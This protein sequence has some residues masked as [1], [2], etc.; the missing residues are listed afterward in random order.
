[1]IKIDTKKIRDGEGGCNYKTINLLCTAYD[2][3]QKEIERLNFFK[4]GHDGIVDEL[5]RAVKENID[6]AV[7]AEKCVKNRDLRISTLET[8]LRDVQNL[9]R[10][11]FDSINHESRCPSCDAWAGSEI[12]GDPPKI[13][14]PDIIH[15]TDCLFTRIQKAL[16]EG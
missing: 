7:D 2:E 8:L 5:V 1:M 12:S 10:S 13:M 15:N 4:Y 16:G 3:A 14:F 11:G 6:R 9:E